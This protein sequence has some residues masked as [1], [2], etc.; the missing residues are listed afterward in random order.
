MLDVVKCAAST[1]FNDSER[2]R[3]WAMATKNRIRSKQNTA[4]DSWPIPST[5]AQFSILSL[6]SI[7]LATRE[8]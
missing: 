3:A 4:S 2:R 7:I 1:V 6:N 8:L 5:P